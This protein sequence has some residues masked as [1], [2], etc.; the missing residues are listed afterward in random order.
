MRKSTKLPYARQPAVAA[1]LRMLRRQRG[2]TAAQ[3]ARAR[4]IE[5]H[6]ARAI[7]SRLASLSGIKI[8]TARDPRRGLVYR[9]GKGSSK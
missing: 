9:A 8:T 7:I 2:V 6:T 1:V 3:I 4:E 5:P